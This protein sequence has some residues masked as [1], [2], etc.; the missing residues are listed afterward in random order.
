[1]DM[2]S[3]QPDSDDEGSR[4]KRRAIAQG[5]KAC[6]PCRARKVR[7]SYQ[8][9]CQTC[10]ERQHPNLCV[11]DAPSKRVLVSSLPSPASSSISP[12][13]PMASHA[14]SSNAAGWT[15]SK[16]DWDKLLG[17]I[18]RLETELQAVR[19]EV[20]RRPALSK[21]DSPVPDGASPDAQADPVQEGVH[22][23]H[24]VTGEHVFL[25]ANSVPAM[26][27]AL[28]QQTSN[29]SA[30][31]RDL[32]DKS[33]LPIFTLE[34]ESTTYPFVDLWGLPHASPVRIEKLYAML[35]SD[36]ECLQYIR[37]YRDTAHVLY[38]A[39]VNMQQFEVEVTRFLITRTTQS[40]D[41]N[42]P[43]L[44]ER[45][46]YGKSVHWLGLLFA[47]LASG[48]QCSNL[49]RRERQLTSQVYV[50]CAYECLRIVNYLSCSQLDDIQNLL[51]L[52]NVIS[53]S[54]NAGV[55]WALLG[56]TIRLAQGLGLHHE[57]SSRDLPSEERVLRHEV[58]SRIIWQDSL[59]SISYD[60][61][62]PT[63]NLTRW[64]MS[65]PA[66][67][68]GGFS[69]TECM[70]RLCTIALDVVSTRSQPMSIQREIQRIE[71]RRAELSST[72]EHAQLHLRQSSACALMKDHLEHWNWRLHCSYVVSEMCRPMLAK[73]QRHSEPKIAELRRVCIDA[74]ADTVDAF[75]KLQ[76]LTFFARTSWA[77]VHR[78]LGSALLLGILGEPSKSESVRQMLEQLVS[79]MTSL[80]Y[81]DASE[82]P[83][84]LTRAVEA[85]QQLNASQDGSEGSQ[86]DSPHAQ[87]QRIL[88]GADLRLPM[89]YFQAL[90]PIEGKD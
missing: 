75:L 43:P 82:M 41:P 58:W 20:S 53:N 6:A 28:S 7:C 52:G 90:S 79:V 63:A 47:C 67:A 69:Y 9:P 15:P 49:P 33:V 17:K 11:Y 22:S 61:A 45:D 29:D 44:T 65:T 13:S 40:G 38:P 71:E 56:L 77:A 1:M 46:V 19:R 51:V 68:D 80:E 12:F 24:P 27:M 37:Q 4:R 30:M 2:H 8:L 26:A 25:G 42:R 48:Y 54:M 18:D 73:R 87:M 70:L 50:C 16:S 86:G 89:E 23:L 55:A 76:N 74:L 60:R 66:N 57:P 32:L 83:A 72:T 10:V 84:P 31:V 81:A 85:L 36:S 88:W 39:I 62:T 64:D 14:S 78:S 35:P 21:L 5:Q 34:N 3:Q 59:L